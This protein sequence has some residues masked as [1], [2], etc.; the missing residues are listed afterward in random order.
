MKLVLNKDI[1]LV[2]QLCNYINFSV[3]QRTRQVPFFFYLHA[4][5]EQSLSV[6]IFIPSF[7][8]SVENVCGYNCL[9]T[10]RSIIWE[11]KE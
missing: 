4:V 7:L 10:L 2:K 9:T 1:I 6:I 11:T 8:N 3:R 5:L